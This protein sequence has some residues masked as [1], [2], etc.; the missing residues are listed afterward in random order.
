MSGPAR[1]LR[2][3]RG[4]VLPGGGADAVDGLPRPVVEE[5]HAPAREQIVLRLDRLE[6]DPLAEGDYYPG[7]LLEDLI[8]A[9]SGQG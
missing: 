2:A 7:D 8:R 1:P 4:T 3:A 9:K 5:R 6:A